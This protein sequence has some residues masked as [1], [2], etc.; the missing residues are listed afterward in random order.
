MKSLTIFLCLL[1]FSAFAVR[2]SNCSSSTAHL[3]DQASERAEILTGEVLEDLSDAI[4][5]RDDI[6]LV[7]KIQLRRSRL[8]INCAKLRMNFLKYKCVYE[9]SANYLMKVLPVIGN[10]V[11]VNTS[12]YIPD[13][14][15]LASAI[16]HE[17]THKCGTDDA[18]Y[19]IQY[20]QKPHSE[21]WSHWSRT[22][23][24]YDYWAY[25]GFCVPEIDC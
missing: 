8:I 23:S 4:R 16:I 2:T 12:S 19:F 7:T 9:P 11:I 25:R 10:K 1:S 17:A 13:R 3:L 18:D 15:Y 22:A 5:T 20:G 21:W 6:P 14:D 24:T